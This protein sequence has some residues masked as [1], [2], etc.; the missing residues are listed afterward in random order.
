MIRGSASPARPIGDRSGGTLAS[1][2]AVF[3]L[4]AKVLGWRIAER[5]RTTRHRDGT[6]RSHPRSAA[7][8]DE[9][10]EFD[11]GSVSSYD[12]VPGAEDIAVTVERRDQT[13]RFFKTLKGLDGEAAS[14]ITHYAVS[15]GPEDIARRLGISPNAIAAARAAS[16]ASTGTTSRERRDRRSGPAPADGGKPR[17]AVRVISLCRALS[18]PG[19]ARPR[20]FPRPRG[21]LKAAADGSSAGNAP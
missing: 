10:C 1:R 21:A 9:L 2:A 16:S 12:T 3:R 20:C 19:S 17:A 13:T 8:L 5:L 14:I 7:S 18:A 15:F 6:A 11:H 4:G